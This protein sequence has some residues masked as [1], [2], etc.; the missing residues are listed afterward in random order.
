L[1]IDQ[2]RE[3]TGPVSLITRRLS[4]E[5]LE[6]TYGLTI[7]DQ[8]G[9]GNVTAE[10]L[11]VAYAIARG[12]VRSGQGNPDEARS[13]RYLL[14]D[15]INGKLLFCH[16]PPFIPEA[17]FNEPTHKNALLRVAGKKRAPTTRV[18]KG[19]DT[20]VQSNVPTPV[21]GEMPMPG[22]KSTKLDQEFFQTNSNLVLHSRPFVQESGKEFTRGKMYPHQNS[23][24]DDGTSIH[25]GQA[26]LIEIAL[27]NADRGKKHKKAKRVKQR[28]GKGYD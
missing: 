8:G 27:Q 14:K 28:S 11:L 6:A 15:Y 17:S 4:K 1:P 21:D 23:V 10:N 19:S 22:I 16:P 20:F 3:Y 25:L 5:I 24:A 13:A 9:D 2:L 12:Y 26:R 18:G 7:K